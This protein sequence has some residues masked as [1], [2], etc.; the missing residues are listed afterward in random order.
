MIYIITDVLFLLPRVYARLP[1]ISINF[2]WLYGQVS[3][4]IDSSI[5][6]ER[7][8][9]KIK[10]ALGG[11]TPGKPLLKYYVLAKS[12]VRMFQLALVSHAR[13]D[14][15]DISVHACGSGCAA[16]G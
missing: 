3:N 13:V 12:Q 9:Y 16:H 6:V 14:V 2:T 7:T 11:I 15:L 8:T 1:L 10:S 4:T 5:Q